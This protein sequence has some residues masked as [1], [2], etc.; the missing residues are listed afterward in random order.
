MLRGAS[1]APHSRA[2]PAASPA[3][4]PHPPSLHLSISSQGT[5]CTGGEK[6]G[7]SACFGA[8]ELTPMPEHGGDEQHGHCSTPKLIS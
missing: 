5:H 1:T 4:P 2:Q 8:L 6:A 3:L 7:G